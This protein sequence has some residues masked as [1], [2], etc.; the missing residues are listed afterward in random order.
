MVP[1]IGIEPTTYWLQISCSANWAKSAYGTPNGIQTRDVALKELWLNHLSMGAYG[2]K[3]LYFLLHIYYSILFG[4]IHNFSCY[5]LKYFLMVYAFVY[6]H[7]DASL[8]GNPKISVG[9]IFLFGVVYKSRTCWHRVTADYPNRRVQTTILVG[10][11]KIAL[12]RA[13]WHQFYRLTRLL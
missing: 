13:T 4:F 12:T 8:T 9:V 5:N 10:N 3:F 2:D 11:E 1:T 7:V 6:I